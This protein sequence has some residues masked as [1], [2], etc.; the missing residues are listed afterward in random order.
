MNRSLD[1]SYKSER[2]R[3]FINH[4][5]NTYEFEGSKWYVLS[6]LKK[7]IGVYVS[8]MPRYIKREIVNLFNNNELDILVVTSAF[9]EGVNSTAKN[10]II[11]N[12]VVGSNIKM[13]PLDLLNLSG[14]AGRFGIHS[15]GNIYSVKEEIHNRLVDC[16]DSGVKISN[17]NYENGSI[18]KDRTMY[19]I[20]IIDKTYLSSNELEIRNNMENLQKEFNLNDEDL[21]VALSISK[22]DKIKLYK[23]FTII[24]NNENI[25]SRIEMINNIMSDKRENVVSSM[26]YIFDELKNAGIEIY[27]DDGD[28]PAYSK[29]GKFLWGIFYGIHS[30]G[31]IKEILKKRKEYI[32]KEYEEYKSD[33]YN[34]NK[35]WIN[36]FI[37]NDTVDDFKLYNQAF[38]FISNIIEYR[39]PFYIGFYISIFKLFCQKNNKNV[40]DYDVIELSNILENKKIEDKFNE[41]LEY[42][43]S[44]DMIK[45]IQKGESLDEFEKIIFDEYK[46]IVS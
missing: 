1:I 9:A 14:R 6:G 33:I 24:G 35:P 8:P 30:S 13:T 42:G 46:K 43:F 44:I 32:I 11:T 39:I 37:S 29:E 26:K 23:Y 40:V 20:E 21:N 38:K 15:Q 12:D 25:E 34:F 5:Q 7:G 16:I 19:D 41:L 10:I 36:D 31:N 22:D 17:L 18:S 45:K 27:K 2:F 28:I 3:K 4:L